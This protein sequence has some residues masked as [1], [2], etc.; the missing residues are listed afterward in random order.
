MGREDCQMCHYPLINK[1]AIR[2]CDYFDYAFRACHE[3]ENCPDGLDKET[4]YWDEDDLM[5]INENDED[6]LYQ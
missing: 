4:E 1:E 3:I 2:C 5:E 6:E